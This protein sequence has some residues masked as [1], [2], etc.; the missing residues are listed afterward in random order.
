MND[1]QKRQKQRVVQAAEEALYKQ[2]Y[3]SPIDVFLGMKLLQPVHVIDWR[4]GRIPYLEQVIQGNLS[5]ISF[6]MK[7]FRAWANEKGLILS[8]TVYLARTRGAKRELRFS[9]TGNSEIER[10]YRTHYIS[11]ALSE[12][13]QKK[14]Q[15]K[16]DNPPELVVFRI[17]QNSQCSQCKKEVK[18]GS[19]LY[20]EA[21][22][23]FCL[24]C[25]DLSML[26][27]LPRGNALL[28]RRVKKESIKC[29]VV[30][31]FSRSR[32]RYERQGILV[33]KESLEKVR[34]EL[35]LESCENDFSDF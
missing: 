35:M 4:K 15:E 19:F 25:A 6:Y 2:Q 1:N 8:P 33:D 34:Q 7:C 29:T 21:G 3:V 12:I 32:S 23:P 31:E 9:K 18:K 26:E 27:Y 24:Y 16:L 20:M 11:P 10:A 22:E 14:I 13:K 17:V 30:V 5:K 28:T